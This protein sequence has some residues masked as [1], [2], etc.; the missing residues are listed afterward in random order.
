M[1]SI[2]GIES[3]LLGE[4][5]ANKLGNFVNVYVTSSFEEIFATCQEVRN[6]NFVDS[7]LLLQ[8]SSVEDA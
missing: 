3:K 4:F 6:L 2:F 7:A 8:E 1:V 5:F